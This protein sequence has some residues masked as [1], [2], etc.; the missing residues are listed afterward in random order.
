[1]T[2]YSSPLPV[3]RPAL[4]RDVADVAEFTKFIWGGHDYVGYVFPEWLKDPRGQLLAAEYAGK[5][6]GC[7]KVSFLAPGQWWLEGFRVDPNHQGL[8]IG[9][10]LDASANE[11]WDAHGDGSLRLLTNSKRVQVHHLSEARGFIRMGEVCAYAAEPLTESTD[12]FTPLRAE[13]ADEA[14][15]FFQRWM[16]SGYLNVGWKFAAPNADSMRAALKD[17]NLFFW[18]R[19]REGIVSAWEDDEEGAS[20]LIVGMEACAGGGRVQLLEDV[21]RLASARGVTVARW[22]NV[23]DDAILRDLDEAGYRKDWEDTAYLYERSHS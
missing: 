3:I 15:A 17:E 8:K 4:P 18:W 7:A 21:R 23:I 10:R 13:E 22:M 2:N 6:V 20:R 11:W 1:M 14:A 16:P 12:A 19:G 9:S 5:C